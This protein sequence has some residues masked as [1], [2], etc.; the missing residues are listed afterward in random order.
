MVLKNLEW[1]IYG[2]I[3]CNITKCKILLTSFQTS[4]EKPIEKTQWNK[5]TGSAKLITC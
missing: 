5:G 3:L 2:Q 1:A 4:K